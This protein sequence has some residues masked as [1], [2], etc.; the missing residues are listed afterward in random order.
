MD[1]KVIGQRIREQRKAKKMTLEVLADKADIGLVYLGEIER[2]IK[3]PSL[4]TFIKI[5]NS[6]EISADILLWD[7]VVAAKGYKL[8]AITERLDGLTP[9]QL[10]AVSNIIDATLAN[11]DGMRE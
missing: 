6:L 8:N 5:V 2:G 9:Q 7:E 10:K 1:K 3:M 4:N 11:M